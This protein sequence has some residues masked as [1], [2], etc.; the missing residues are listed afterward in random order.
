MQQNCRLGE[1]ESE[2]HMLMEGLLLEGLLLLQFGSA[3]HSDRLRL[4]VQGH[5]TASPLSL[6]LCS[7]HLCRLGDVFVFCKVKGSTGTGN[8]QPFYFF[9]V[10]KKK[11]WGYCESCDGYEA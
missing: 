4:Q 5:S 10:K 11:V 8:K 6:Q 7:A 1:L 3:I 9:S 2:H